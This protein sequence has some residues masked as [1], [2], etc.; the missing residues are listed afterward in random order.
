MIGNSGRWKAWGCDYQDLFFLFLLQL[1]NKYI[2]HRKG[3]SWGESFILLFKG[4]FCPFWQ[5][6]SQVPR[7]LAPC[8]WHVATHFQSGLCLA[9]PLLSHL[10]RL[11]C[12]GLRN[13]S[14]LWWLVLTW[15]DLLPSLASVAFSWVIF[16]ASEAFSLALYLVSRAFY[17][18][19]SSVSWA[20][21]EADCDALTAFTLSAIDIYVP[22]LQPILFWFS[23]LDLDQVILTFTTSFI[24]MKTD[25]LH[26]LSDLTSGTRTERHGCKHRQSQA[27]C[28]GFKALEASHG[29]QSSSIISMHH[30]IREWSTKYGN[31]NTW[32]ITTHMRFGEEQ[33]DTHLTKSLDPNAQEEPSIKT[34]HHTKT[35]NLKPQFLTKTI[36]YTPRGR[37]WD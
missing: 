21:W 37:D 30:L 24:S 7:L 32:H 26:L 4:Y 27:V 25:L 5:S 20:F 28:I 2:Y 19:D 35:L 3:W 12:F 11:R 34:N 6:S 16:E 14:R 17:E 31:G 13:L 18:S 1:Q 29:T 8:H 9:Q 22:L 36:T 15:L 33:K 23:L 10:C